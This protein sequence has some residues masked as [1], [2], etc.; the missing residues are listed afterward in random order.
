MVSP[1]VCG[2]EAVDGRP[3]EVSQHWDCSDTRQSGRSRI[4]P[5]ACKKPVRLSP[6][7]ERHHLDVHRRA[8]EPRMPAATFRT[9]PGCTTRTLHI[10]RNAGF[11]WKLPFVCLLNPLK[12]H[13]V[14]RVS[15]KSQNV[16]KRYPSLE[17]S[18]S[19]F[20]AFETLS[21]RLRAGITFKGIVFIVL[22]LEH[23]D[24]HCLHFALQ[25][26]MP[27][28]HHAAFR[29]FEGART[30]EA[31]FRCVF[32]LGTMSTEWPLCRIVCVRS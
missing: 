4:M 19:P 14:T 5:P 17:A 20:E 15:C 29:F 11:F 12:L 30:G 23:S 18:F 2:M 24:L 8:L 7:S 28:K 27:L 13:N 31:W 16:F 3:R 10:M 9:C 32:C 1:V 26:F 21:L 6:L 22:L 25:P